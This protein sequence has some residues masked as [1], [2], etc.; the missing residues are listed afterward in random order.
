LAKNPQPSNSQPGQVS[1]SDFGARNDEPAPYEAAPKFNKRKLDDVM[2]AMDVVDTLRSDAVLL[3]QD[4]SANEREQQLVDRLKVIYKNQGIDVPERILREGVKALDEE[5]FAYEPY[6]GGFFSKIY[7]SRGRWGKP[8][9]VA[10]GM[11]GFAVTAQY[12]LIEMPKKH[13]AKRIEQVLS[14][15]VSDMLKLAQTPEVQ[16]RIRTLQ[17]DGQLALKTKNTSEAKNIAEALDNLNTDL[18]QNYIVRIVSRPG[19]SS[20]VFR[21]PPNSPEGRN[22]YLIVEGIDARGNTVTVLVNSE[23]DQKSERVKIWGVRVPLAVYQSVSADK[24]DDQIIQNAVIG[25]KKRGFLKPDYKIETI[26][27][28]G[29]RI[30]DW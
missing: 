24:R 10:L 7:I 12:A 22:Y 16:S 13:E 17:A 26:N 21:I 27:T 15:D 9:I 18:N 28:G 11:I 4:L 2:L 19:E 25:V 23:E 3:E 30:L 6:K 5:R 20:G 8:T 29:S 1:L 14:A